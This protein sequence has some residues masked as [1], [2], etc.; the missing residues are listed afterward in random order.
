MAA[1][2]HCKLRLIAKLCGLGQFRRCDRKLANLY[3]RRRYQTIRYYSVMGLVGFHL[4][5]AVRNNHWTLVIM[6]YS[7]A[8]LYLLPPSVHFIVT[9]EV[10][11]SLI[12]LGEDVDLNLCV[13]IFHSILAACQRENHQFL[14]HLSRQT[15]GL[16]TQFLNFLKTGQLSVE[17][18]KYVT[19]PSGREQ[20]GKFIYLVYFI[21]CRVKV[22]LVVYPGNQNGLNL[23]CMHAR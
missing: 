5:S 14:S 9:Q 1:Q 10:D 19:S 2:S 15:S 11:K 23:N 13:L 6:V 18:N 4:F 21:L 8:P 16:L 7:L 22:N 17:I 12:H 20:I 3:R